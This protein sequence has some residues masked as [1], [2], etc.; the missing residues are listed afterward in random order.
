MKK[1][2]IYS[3]A[4]IGVLSMVGCSSSDISDKLNE[5]VV[6]TG[7]AYYVDSAVEGVK[8]VCGTKE[9][10]TGE[11]GSF[12]FEKGSS[13]TFYL[14]NIK[15][16]DL[17][18]DQLVDGKEILETNLEI[19][20][21][22]QTL[23]VD[24]DPS[25]G[26]TIDATLVDAMI[27]AGITKLP[28]TEAELAKFKEVMAYNEVTVVTDADAKSHLIKTAI[29]NKTLYQNCQNVTGSWLAE[30]TFNENGILFIND[31]GEEEKVEFKIEAGSVFTLEEEGFKERP[32]TIYE[33]AVSFGEG[34]DD[35]FY[36]TKED[37]LKSNPVSCG[38]GY[39][40]PTLPVIGKLALAFS[41]KTYFVTDKRGMLEQWTFADDLKSSSLTEM[42][43]G[44]D[45]GFV[46]LESNEETMEITVFNPNG[47]ID[48]L[49]VLSI[50]SDFVEIE[51]NGSLEKIFMN[52]E[53]AKIDALNKFKKS[54]E[55]KVFFTSFSQNILEE[56][57]F[58]NPFNT[59]RWTELSGEEETGLELVTANI[60][61][62]RYE[63]TFSEVEVLGGPS[64]TMVFGAFDENNIFFDISMGDQKTKI[65]LNK[66]DAE[67]FF[68][69]ISIPTPVPDPVI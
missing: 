32:V 17:R 35:K 23:D 19:A 1:S 16:R 48:I 24:G 25:N 68:F 27:D 46:K 69:R 11:D 4:A 58:S 41:G 44:A 21:I 47:E 51:I 34:D 20:K 36:F 39:E 66:L 42:I 26:I 15:L 6:E 52:L 13:C 18:V 30:L 31:S 53:E 62:N 14:D 43:G 22:L 56:L 10:L 3:L 2:F 55:G 28:Q 9:G 65:F 12:I 54:F 57:S 38:D 7:T 61:N 59:M 29:I 49:K 67:N 5:E 8:Y 37:A 64:E 40:E 50:G 63:M 33:E 45:K 60:V